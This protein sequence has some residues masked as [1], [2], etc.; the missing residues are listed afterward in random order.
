MVVMP[1]GAGKSGVAVLAPYVLGVRKCLVVSP[2]HTITKQLRNDFLGGPNRQDKPF[3]V[4]RGMPLQDFKDKIKPT[5]STVLRRSDLRSGDF[6]AKDLLIT[7]AHKFL[8]EKNWADV[9]PLDDCDLVIVDEA[10]HFPAGFWMHIVAAAESRKKQVCRCGHYNTY[11]HTHVNVH[12]HTLS[13]S[14]TC[15]F[16]HNHIFTTNRCFF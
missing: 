13:P 10:H 3:F 12:T 6:D 9:F 5:D 15:T 7:N 2:S 11:A 14:L 4:K 1:T 8:D 16:A